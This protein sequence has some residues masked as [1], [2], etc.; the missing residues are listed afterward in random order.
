MSSR[1]SEKAEIQR[2][3]ELLMRFSSSH[4]RSGSLVHT[5]LMSL[6]DQIGKEQGVSGKCKD[7][8]TATLKVGDS[9]TLSVNIN[10]SSYPVPTSVTIL[11]SQTMAALKSYI[12]SLNG[13]HF[14]VERI[15]NRR[16]GNAWGTFDSRILGQVGLCNGD[17]IIVDCKST[18][19]NTNPTGLERLQGS[20]IVAN[21]PF[22]LIA[23]ALHCYMLDAGFIA[24]TELPNATPGFAP[25]L[26][27]L[28]KG[29]LL[30]SNW[31]SDP[32]VVNAMYKHKERPGKQFLLSCISMDKVIMVTV[33]QRKGTALNMELSEDHFATTE[34]ALT[35]INA[36]EL[37]SKLQTILYQLIPS[38]KPVQPMEV[39]STMGMNATAAGVAT[40]ASATG[41]RVDS[42]PSPDAPTHTPAPTPA[43]APAPPVGRGG[44]GAG[45]GVGVGGGVGNR[46]LEPFPGGVHI[47]PIHGG[48]GG[49]GGDGNV[50]GGGGSLVGPNN[51]IF[52]PDYYDEDYGGYPYGGGGGGGGGAGMPSGLGGIGGLPQPRFDPF[53]PVLGPNVDPGGP[54]VGNI[55]PRG[56]RGG[57]GR[58]RGRGRGSNWMPPGEPNPD[59]FKPPGW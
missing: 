34:P 27:E 54:G 58:G 37:T 39:D 19:E 26:K 14:E 42:P 52:Q 57:A 15:T 56:G 38:L 18:V 6:L 2:E 1:S 8:S 50:N 55:G 28:P 43:P 33:S 16:T 21:S 24:I 41:Y 59:H 11:R 48:A 17:E 25:S 5:R 30:A 12:Q 51:P 29:I 22:Q 13:P 46:D 10:H 31:N 53:G 47:G 35:I 49:V 45:V 40:A 7:E 36:E 3:L 20:G 9:I 32:S 44:I 23:V 4:I